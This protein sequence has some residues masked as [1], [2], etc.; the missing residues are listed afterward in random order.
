MDMGNTKNAGDE[1][2]NKTK[3]NKNKEKIKLVGVLDTHWR[4]VGRVSDKKRG[5]T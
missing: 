4:E 5:W 2:L 3:Q 1:A